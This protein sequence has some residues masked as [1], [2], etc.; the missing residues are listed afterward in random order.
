MSFRDY[1]QF[2]NSNSSSLKPKTD[3]LYFCRLCDLNYKLS[4][5]DAGLGYNGGFWKQTPLIATLATLR[6][7]K[8][9]RKSKYVCGVHRVT[10]LGMGLI[11]LQWWRCRSAVARRGDACAAISSRPRSFQW[12][13]SHRRAI[14]QSANSFRRVSHRFEV[15]KKFLGRVS[16]KFWQSV[17][18]DR[19]SEEG[20]RGETGQELEGWRPK[21][22]GWGGRGIELRAVLER[23]SRSGVIWRLRRCFGRSTVTVN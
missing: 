3:Y 13:D 19:G 4:L 9:L 21:V 10:L 6:K 15:R 16:W 14:S 18:G 8:H 20:E 17:G 1:V 22:G 5:D 2:M 12:E 23:S 7:L 11:L